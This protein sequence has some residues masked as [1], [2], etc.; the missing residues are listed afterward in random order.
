MVCIHCT[1]SGMESTYGPW[2]TYR[3]T[4][5]EIPGSFRRVIEYMTNIYDINSRNT[6]YII[7][8]ITYSITDT[9]SSITNIISDITKITHDITNI[10]DN[11]INIR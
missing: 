5:R 7:A 3:S 11:T 8:T 6:A 1:A 9:T 2:A 10:K 4:P